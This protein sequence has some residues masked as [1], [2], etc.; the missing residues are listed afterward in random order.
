MTETQK[1]IEAYKKALPEIRERVIAVALL[2]AM[3]MAMM[4][5]AT[6]AWLTISRAPEVTAVNTTVAANGNLEIALAT[7]DG[8]IAPGESQVGDSSANE[9]QSVTRANIT[10]GNLV[11]LSD[12]SYGLDNLIMRPALLNSSELL[13]NPLFSAQ[14]DDDGRV[15]GL[16]SGFEYTSWVMPTATTEGYFGLAEK[17]GVRAVSSTKATV[18]GFA[19]DLQ[20]KRDTANGTNA[21]AKTQLL[22]ITRD[23]DYQNLLA[24][25]VSIHMT[26][27]MNGEDKYKNATITAEQLEQMIEMYNKFKQAF[28]KEIEAISQALDAQY[29]S[30]YGGNTAAYDKPTVESVLAISQFDSS[31]NYVN[32]INVEDNG[33]VTEKEIK[34]INLEKFLDNY[35]TICEN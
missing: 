7:G 24:S 2:F 15:V 16:K 22:E 12:P 33:K 23:G 32:K 18:T 11:N 17:M 34:I 5:S 30:A 1:R 13:T 26:A 27:E 10:W 3:S 6:F 29:F 14:Y 31:G 28:E 4:T 20:L 35:K 19:Y 8:T 25:L 9:E 21:M